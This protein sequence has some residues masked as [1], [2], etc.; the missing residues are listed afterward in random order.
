MSIMENTNSAIKRAIAE[1]K[2]E[3]V[4]QDLQKSANKLTSILGSFLDNSATEINI[5]FK[6]AA[7]EPN[8]VSKNN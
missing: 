8:S 7:S 4:E 6:N 3:N 1:N 5:N 2:T